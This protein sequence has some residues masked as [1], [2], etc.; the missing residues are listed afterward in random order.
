MR[1]RLDRF[2]TRN[3]IGWAVCTLAAAAAMGVA[4]FFSILL[5]SCHGGGGFCASELDLDA[6]LEGYVVGVALMGL[7]AGLVA[8]TFTRRAGVLAAIVTGALMVVSGYVLW[9]EAV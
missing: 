7:S 3:R 6:I 1:Q 5:G 4:G 2:A 8:L 9:L